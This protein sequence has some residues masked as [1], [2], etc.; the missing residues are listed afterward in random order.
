MEWKDIFERN[1]KLTKMKKK[2]SK[3]DRKL[4]EFEDG[5]KDKDE[6]RS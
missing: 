6:K 5:Y 2:A 4:T 1:R 3:K